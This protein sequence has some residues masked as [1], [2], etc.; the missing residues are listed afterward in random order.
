[1]HLRPC[2]RV[3]R[4]DAKDFGPDHLPVTPLDFTLV[5]VGVGEVHI[6]WALLYLFPGLG[7]TGANLTK[8][9]ALAS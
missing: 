9:V 5:T 3:G 1:M 7:L 2:V 8:M 6:L 4:L